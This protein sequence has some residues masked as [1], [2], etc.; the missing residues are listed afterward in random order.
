MPL[1]LA[2]LKGAYCWG[3]ASALDI[4]PL[5]SYILREF[6]VV[7]LRVVRGGVYVKEN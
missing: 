5:G 7:Y 6:A 3:A 4:T 2:G 1:F